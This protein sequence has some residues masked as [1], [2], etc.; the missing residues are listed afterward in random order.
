F[1]L[2]PGELPH[3]DVALLGMGDDGHTASL[4][5]DTDALDEQEHLVVANHVP[6]LDTTRIT[7]TLPVLNAARTVLVLL[8]G[9]DKAAL[10]AEVLQRSE[11]HYPIQRVQPDDGKLIWMIDRP[12]ARGLRTSS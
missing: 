8:R 9:A 1:D 5:P 3:L 2:E 7:V 4:F 10:L 12:A 11:P 6:H